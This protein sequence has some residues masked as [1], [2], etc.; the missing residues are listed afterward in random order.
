MAS[1]HRAIDLATLSSKEVYFLLTSL[2]VPRPIAWVSTVDKEGRSNLAPF[3][4]FNGVCS[5]PPLISIA[6]GDNRDG[7]KDS[8]RAMEETQVFCVNLVED[9]HLEAMHQSSGAFPPE[10]SEFDVT[11]TQSVVCDTISCLRVADA[12]AAFEC[13]LV[14]VHKYGNKK[15]INLVIGE[16]LRAHLSPSICMDDKIMA[17]P[18]KMNPVARLGSGAYALLQSPFRKAPVTVP[19]PDTR[20]VLA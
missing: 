8:F 9:Q 5:D 4:Y 13:R 14:D 16:I 6:I 7:P 3:S 11:Q 1:M 20:K 15:K 2:V 19:A 12:R 18:A 10:V 17:D